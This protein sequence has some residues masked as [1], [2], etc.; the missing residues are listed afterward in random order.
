MGMNESLKRGIGPLP[1]GLLSIHSDG[2]GVISTLANDTST[3]QKVVNAINTPLYQRETFYNPSHPNHLYSRTFPDK[4]MVVLYNQSAKYS[5]IS[6]LVIAHGPKTFDRG[7]NELV[8][9]EY[10]YDYPETVQQSYWQALFGGMK[11]LQ[12][13]APIENMRFFI[14]EN[15]ISTYSTFDKRTSRSIGNPHAHIVGFIEEHIEPRST[16]ASEQVQY[17]AEEQ[18]FTKR[19]STQITRRVHNK[20]PKTLQDQLVITP[21][22]QPPFGYSFAIPYSVDEIV[23]N[24]ETFTSLMTDHHKAYTTVAQ[25]MEKVYAPKILAAGF[26][27][28]IPQP[29]YRLYLE[30]VDGQL[31]AAI[32]PEYISHAGIIEARSYSRSPLILDRNASYPKRFSDELIQCVQKDAAVYIEDILTPNESPKR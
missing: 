6:A 32:S 11:S 30:E 13:N 8:P 9:V 22:D 10:I 21:Q 4:S 18:E 19:L 25:Q 14:G 5:E 20:L 27:Q 26:K 15:N 12:K 7:D 24:P 16:K 29:S 3:A 17:L 2:T 31:Y 1:S 23:T 28:F